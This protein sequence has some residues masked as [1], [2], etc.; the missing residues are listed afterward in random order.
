MRHDTRVF[1][2]AGARTALACGLCAATVLAYG[3]GGSG[4][5]SGNSGGPPPSGVA[6]S[7]TVSAPGGALAFNGPTTFERMLASVFGSYAHAAIT[8]VANVGAGVTINLIEVNAAGSQVGD[9]IATTTTE[10]DGSFALTAPEGF[11]PGPQYVLRAEGTTE[12]IDARVTDTTVNADPVTDAT[13]DLVT[14]TASDLSALSTGEIAEI[15]DVVEGLTSDIDPTGLSADE[16]A[17]ALGAAVSNDEEA[18]NVVSSTVS[19]GQICGNVQ[20]STGT[21]LQNIRIVVRDY[22]NWVTRNKTLTDSSGDY[23]VNVPDGDYI[24]GALNYTGASFGASEWWSTGGTAYSQFDGERVTVAGTTPIT[25]DFVLEPGGRIAGSV[26][27]AAGGDYAQGTP[28]ENVRVVVRFFDTLTPITSARVK[29]D[30]T[31][32]VN[33][34]PGNYLLEIRNTTLQWAYGSEMYSAGGGTDGMNTTLPVNV[35]AG[36]TVTADA[37]LEPGFMLSGS[38]VDNTTDNNPVTGMR[39]RVDASNGPAARLRT[40]KQGQYRIWLRPGSYVVASY[41]SPRQAVDLSSTS[42]TLSFAGPV[43]TITGV[44]QDSGGQPVSQVKVFLRDAAGNFVN[45]EVSSSDGSFTLYSTATA[46]DNNITFRI[47]DARDYGSSVYL[48]Q[49]RAADATPVAVTVGGNTDLGTIALPDAGVLTGVVVQ[50][51]GVTPAQDTRVQVRSGGS[52]GT[53]KFVDVYTRGDGSYVV[54]LP[55]G[56]YDR[57]RAGLTVGTNAN[58]VNITAGSTTTQNFTMP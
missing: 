43:G 34:A 29:A 41:G 7:G 48:N 33:V 1:P 9:V 44:L 36:A 5:D 23:C 57:V 12:T 15:Q 56:T 10:S 30:G 35:T 55:A 14:A 40:D 22:G 19:A 24:V 52:L 53:D 45:Q 13:S 50:A 38:I 17:G 58:M 42:Q 46:V 32:R 4:S 39:V 47:D 11:T 37:E 51:D 21:S 54:S 3:C 6:V 25:R 31:F 28:L 49:T 16:L 18:N 26:T 8:G 27:A 2:R 20:S